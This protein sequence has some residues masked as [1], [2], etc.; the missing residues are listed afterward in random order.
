MAAT[1][2]LSFGSFRMAGVIAGVA[3]LSAGLSLGALWLFGYPFGFMAI[4]GTMGLVGVAIND[5]I[6]VMAALREDEQAKLGEP[7]AVRDVLLRHAAR[8]RDFADNDGRICAPGARWRRFL[9][10][11]GRGDRR[12]R[13]RRDN[14]RDLFCALGI[15][16]HDVPRPLPRE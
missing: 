7:A 3:A 14:S 5:A 6:V 13:W 8:G 11:A 16:P 1:L 4:V 15:H 2:V 12:R 9:A 10:S